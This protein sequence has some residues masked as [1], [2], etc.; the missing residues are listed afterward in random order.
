MTNY[1]RGAAFERATVTALSGIGYVAGRFA[2]SKSDMG[3]DVIA[4]GHKR[5]LLVQCKTGSRGISTE[6]WNDF[7]SVVTDVVQRQHMLPAHPIVAQQ[8]DIVKGKRTANVFYLLT[9][10]R[11]SNMRQKNWPC[12]R[13]SLHDLIEMQKNNDGS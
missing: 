12:V 7:Y 2:G 8:G 11:A 3:A 5:I 10:V 1:Q 4:L 13:H 6:E 9:G